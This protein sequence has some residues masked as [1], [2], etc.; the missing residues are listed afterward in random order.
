MEA[1][2]EYACDDL[3]KDAE[4]AGTMNVSSLRT[5]EVMLHAVV[6]TIKRSMSMMI[7]AT[8]SFGTKGASLTSSSANFSPSFPV[9]FAK[10]LYLISFC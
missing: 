5:S 10:H 8:Y 3:N 9:L 1:A 7:D 6:V 2:A 4:V